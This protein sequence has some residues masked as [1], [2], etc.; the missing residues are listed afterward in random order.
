MKL[1]VIR[2]GIALDVGEKGIRRDVDRPLS[3]EGRKKTA[4][5]AGGLAALGCRPERIATSP[6]PRAEQ[7]A[8][9]L[10]EKAFPDAQVETC[11][12]LA[13]GASASAVV[14]WLCRTGAQE[15]AVVGHMPDLGHIISDLLTGACSLDL[16]L[17]KAGVCCIEFDEEPQTGAGRLLWLMEPKALAAV[18]S[19]GKA[20]RS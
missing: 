3:A 9:I 19:R 1:Y 20:L 6:L 12:F 8:R 2:H 17:K 14:D 16:D 15:A 13:P 18:K 10:A 11:D 5:V 7:T 4:R